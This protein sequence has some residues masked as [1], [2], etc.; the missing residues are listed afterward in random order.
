LARGFCIAE[1]ALRRFG[2]K[3]IVPCE[4]EIS[5]PTLPDILTSKAE[6][7]PARLPRF[8]VE[9]RADQHRCSYAEM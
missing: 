8:R 2:E 6:L 9:L 3:H 4:T 7:K 5:P 1:R